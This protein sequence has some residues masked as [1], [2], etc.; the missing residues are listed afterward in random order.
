MNQRLHTLAA[1]LISGALLTVHTDSWAQ[2][3]NPEVEKRIKKAD[4][5]L[6]AKDY[7]Q[8][9]PVYLELD[10]LTPNDPANHYA[11]GLCYT[12]AGEPQKALPYLKSAI[13][14]KNQDVPNKVH[15]WYGKSL[16]L[17]GKFDDAIAALNNFR[18]SDNNVEL[19]TEAAK[20]VQ[21][22]NVAKAL[23]SKPEDVFIQS[24][25][26]IN[27][28][29]TEYGPVISADES[30]LI[31]TTIKKNTTPGTS[32]VKEYEDV[33]ITH[34]NGSQWGPS[35]SVGIP[36][37]VANGVRSNIGSV[38]LSPDGQKLLV[39]I[40]TT[41]NSAD[42]YSSVLQGD[43]WGAPAKLG[44]EVNSTYQENSASFTPDEKVVYFASNRPGGLG[45]L[46]IYKA[47]KQADGSWGA[48]VNLGPTVN[49][50]YDEEAPFIHPDKKTLYF[51][52]NGPN[53]MGGTDIFKAVNDKGKWTT[54]TNVGAPVNSVYNDSYFALS[55]DGKKGYFS[56]DRPGGKGG[57]DIYFLGIPE[58][59]GVV[60]LTL[61]KGRILAGEPAKPVKTTIKV[62]DKLTN[63][64]IKGVYNPNAKTGD[65]L[66]IFPPNR[67]YDMI[68]E[69]EGFKPYL[70]NIHVPNQDYFYELYQEI[71]LLPVMKDGKVV[72]QGIAVKNAFEDVDKGKA[73][74]N[75]DNVYALMGKI[76]T[77]E[78]SLALGALLESVYSDPTDVSSVTKNETAA[79]AKYMYN[80]ASGKMQATKVGNETVYT[81]AA[82]DTK[83]AQAAANAKKE[84]ITQSTV[85]KPNQV[86]IV[87]FDTDKADLK[88][89]AKPELDK[90]YEFLKKNP[91]YGV[92][93][94]GHTDNSGTP[95]RNLAISDSRAKAVVGY[96]VGKGIVAKRANAKG[97]GQTEP[98]NDNANEEEKKKNRR[99]E[100]TFVEMTQGNLSSN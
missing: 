78:D 93:I 46:D 73:K 75:N 81:M 60:A 82:L 80:D 91:T 12:Q 10:K 66:I 41:A 51:T 71:V 85:L 9:I 26:A 16:H 54:P 88:A 30:V 24:V 4:A 29:S 8:A 99:V 50:K 1:L 13:E 36:V 11:L 57:S 17:S 79:E 67:Q 65:Y 63:E 33:M 97:Y 37:P 70:V 48:P 18:Q 32:S 94:A 2:A 14:S 31:Y 21:Q 74:S 19:V 35:Q 44:R 76:L 69:A 100:I 6:A 84:V 72:G 42:I 52:S 3:K 90:V 7:K 62:V 25:D 83:A 45:G 20:L 64:V 15:F 96:L 5:F 95:D 28:P 58:E 77:A 98:L 53:S 49:S 56:S 39:Y 61:M 86:Y 40:G 27:T 47:E 22:C 43:K 87:Y 55:A 59:L 68:I 34:K 23:T 92:K 38:G 89:D